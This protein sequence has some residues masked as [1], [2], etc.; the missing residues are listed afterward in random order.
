VGPVGDFAVEIG[1][2]FSYFANRIRGRHHQPAP[3]KRSFGHAFRVEGYAPVEDE[4]RSNVYSTS[5]ASRTSYD[6]D[7]R[8][9]PYK[10][11]ASD[12][13]SPEDVDVYRATA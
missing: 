3:T 10:A 1:S 5:Y 7:I 4:L 13:R 12:L 8:L 2:E 6:E 9:T 11:S